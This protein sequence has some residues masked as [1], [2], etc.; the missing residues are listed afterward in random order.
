MYANYLAGEL[1][2]QFDPEDARQHF[3]ASEAALKLAK[4]GPDNL[5][6]IRGFFTREPTTVTSALLTSIS[7][8]GP[9]V[10]QAGIRRIAV[11]TLVIGHE[12]DAVH[13][14]NYARTLANWI[15]D[16]RFVEI[17]PKADDAEA[18]RH[19]FRAALARF[20]KEI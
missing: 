10:S 14:L 15:P 6:S 3:E 20:L 7:S 4:D 18:Y 17:T 19:D 11:P 16:S 12:R 2:R 1:L 13:P 9:G 8:D 5:A